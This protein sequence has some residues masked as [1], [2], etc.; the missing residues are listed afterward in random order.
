MVPTRR[1]KSPIRGPPLFVRQASPI[2]RHQAAPG[3]N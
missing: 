1:V 2:Q 3:T